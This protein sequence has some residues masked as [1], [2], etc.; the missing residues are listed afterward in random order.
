MITYFINCCSALCV[1]NKFFAR[2][3]HRG[4]YI[5]REA[6]TGPW[7]LLHNRHKKI[8]GTVKK[9]RLGMPGGTHEV[10]VWLHVVDTRSADG[11][12]SEDART[13]SNPSRHIYNPKGKKPSLSLHIS[14]IPSWSITFA[15]RAQVTDDPGSGS[16]MQDVSRSRPINTGPTREIQR[17]MALLVD[18][19]LFHLLEVKKKCYHAPGELFPTAGSV[20]QALELKAKANHCILP[21]EIP[22]ASC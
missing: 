11:L 15:D 18:A 9:R 6:Q 7:L 2:K 3:Y 16:R 19:G 1:S 21:K 4:Y 5:I 13:G 17:L 22:E 12:D 8:M 14:I 20:S 10:R